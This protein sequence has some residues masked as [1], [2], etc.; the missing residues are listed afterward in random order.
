MGQYYMVVNLE[1]REYLNPLRFGNGCKV[2]EFGFS[3]YGVMSALAILLAKSSEIAGGGE[4]DSEITGAWAGNRI[5]I[6]GDYDESG[7]YQR[8]N[9]DY[10]DVSSEV[11]RVMMQDEHCGQVLRDRLLFLRPSLKILEEEEET[12]R[13]REVKTEF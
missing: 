11:L 12:H 6:I 3:S 4:F 7:L 5:V 10:V 1:R 2:R 8:L 9:D 13:L